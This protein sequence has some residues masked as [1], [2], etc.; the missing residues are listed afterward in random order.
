MITSP[1][2]NT[3]NSIA[4]VAYAGIVHPSHKV[5]PTQFTSFAITGD[6]I[7]IFTQVA[8]WRKR[9][10]YVLPAV[11]SPAGSEMIFGNQF[12]AGTPAFFIWEGY[13]GMAG[14]MVTG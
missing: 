8:R 1:I 5:D 2:N 3:R 6:L 12:L 4:N 13:F 7:V 11:V 9:R 14:C 10:G